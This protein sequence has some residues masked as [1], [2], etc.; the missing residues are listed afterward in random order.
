VT[1]LRRRAQAITPLLRRVPDSRAGGR[2]CWDN[3]LRLLGAQP[4]MHHC[5]LVSPTVPTVATNSFQL[6]YLLAVSLFDRKDYEEPLICH[7]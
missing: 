3:G 4:A 2:C 5:C 1:S 7:R 6:V